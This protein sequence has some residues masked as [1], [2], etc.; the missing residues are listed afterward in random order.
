MEDF[1]ELKGMIKRLSSEVNDLK[2]QMGTAT[3]DRMLDARGLV[4]MGIPRAAA[5]NLFNRADFPT[6]RI[7]RRLFV[8]SSKLYEFLDTK[9]DQIDIGDPEDAE[10]KK[11]RLSALSRRRKEGIQL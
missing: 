5:Y 7:G 8:R 6:I 11:E 9:G 3:L 1:E 4:A 2:K 10:E